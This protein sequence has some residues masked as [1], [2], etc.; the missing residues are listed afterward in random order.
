MLALLPLVDGDGDGDLPECYP[1]LTPGIPS[2][3]TLHLLNLK[4]TRALRRTAPVSGPFTLAQG[5]ILN[6]IHLNR[7]PNHHH[8]FNMQRKKRMPWKAIHQADV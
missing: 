3:P 1:A 2:S 4:R 8:P 5:T 6:L 7:S